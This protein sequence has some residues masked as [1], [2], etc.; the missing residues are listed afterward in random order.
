[1][2]SSKAG[3]SFAGVLLASSALLLP[4]SATAQTSGAITGQ[5]LDSSKAAVADA[6][7]TAENV[8]TGE[9]RSVQTNSQGYYTLTELRVGT[10]DISAERQGFRRTV[11]KGV[12]LNV[13]TTVQL[14][15]TLEVGAVNDQVFVTS[16]TPVIEK[17][18]ASTGTT[19]ETQQ[20]SD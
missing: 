18:D 14:N 16:E 17:S 13:A 3:F 10:Y 7:V 2:K 19:M 9:T 20:L 4:S 5:V 15:F 6:T 8:G 11:Q 12:L 1:M